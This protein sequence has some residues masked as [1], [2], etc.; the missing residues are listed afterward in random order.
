[1]RIVFVNLKGIFNINFWGS[2]IRLKIS[3]IAP[4]GHTQPQNSLF[5]NKVK[6]IIVTSNEKKIT[7]MV[8][9]AYMNRKGFVTMH[10]G[11]G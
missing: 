2:G 10:I 5:P 8:F 11:L 4:I 1:M 9:P 7:G 6:I 3:C